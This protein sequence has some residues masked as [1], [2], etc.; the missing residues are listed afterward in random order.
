[1]GSGSFGTIYHLLWLA[2]VASPLV[3]EGGGCGVGMHSRV[4][5][6]GGCRSVPTWVF[7][8]WST[9]GMVRPRDDLEQS[10]TQ[11]S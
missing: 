7:L 5:V 3:R 8:M 9:A 1:M 2:Y 11:L 4:H 6:H 10:R